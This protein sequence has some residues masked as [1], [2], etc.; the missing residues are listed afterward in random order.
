[1]Q[2]Q[3]NQTDLL[4]AGQY[5][6]VYQI[7]NN[8]GFSIKLSNLGC[9]LMEVLWPD[10]EGML[11][12]ILLGYDSIADWQDDQSFFGSTAGRCCNRIRDSSVIIGDKE[13]AL[14]ANIPPHQ[15]HGGLAGFNKKIWRGYPF[16]NQDLAGVTMYYNSRHLEEGFPG[17]LSVEAIISLT[18]KNELI[19][20][21]KATT[22]QLTVCNLT[23]HPYFNL[24][25]SRDILDHTLWIDADYITEID[26]D[27]VTTGHSMAVKETPF[28]FTT[29]I[30]I[31]KQLAKKH[32]QKTLSDHGIDHNFILNQIPLDTPAASLSSTT[33]G[34]QIK[35]YTNQPGIQLY[36][37]NHLNFMG[38]KGK[39][40]SKYA[41][42]CLETQGFPNA[43]NIP[44]FPSV[45][46]HPGQHYYSYTKLEMIG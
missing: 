3:V 7:T 13:Y 4:R 30:Q 25:G 15:L 18:N 37:A 14:N 41:G 2:V 43:A 28:D 16:T 6:E 21:Y 1:M 32:P 22:D 5:I 46:L 33:S 24:D 20:E 42:V 17:N 31:G 19:I 44:G 12:D 39:H 45:L 34:R 29:P 23:S 26:S 38:K 11:N 10:S 9:T 27:F 40:Y 35:L 36:T 8:Q